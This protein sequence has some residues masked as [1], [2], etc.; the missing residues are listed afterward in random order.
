MIGNRYKR[1]GHFNEIPGPPNFRFSRPGATF[2]QDALS[3]P[4]SLLL[5]QSKKRTKRIVRLTEELTW[6]H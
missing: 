4:R 3:Y 5:D 6:A 2:C 1:E